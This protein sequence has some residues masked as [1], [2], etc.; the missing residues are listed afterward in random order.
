MAMK[1]GKNADEGGMFS[2]V[3]TEGRVSDVCSFKGGV[4]LYVIEKSFFL[5]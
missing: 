3:V 4:T 1:E 5:S 2:D